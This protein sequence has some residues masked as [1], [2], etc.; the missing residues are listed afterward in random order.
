MRLAELAKLAYPEDPKECA[1]NLRQCFLQAMPT[2][3]SAKIEDTE[4][5]I[6]I[7]SGGSTK[8][9]PFFSLVEVATDLQDAV[10]TIT[11]KKVMWAIQPPV[12]G[13]YG[14]FQSQTVDTRL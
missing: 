14:R 8:Y 13:H 1:R 10:G 6:K 7:T 2:H 9:L 11:P 3:I 5:S 12:N 4:K